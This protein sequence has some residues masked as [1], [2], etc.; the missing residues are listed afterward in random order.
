MCRLSRTQWFCAAF[1]LVALRLVIGWHFFQEGTAKLRAGNFSAEGFFRSANGPAADFYRRLIDDGDGRLRLGL[2]QVTKDPGHVEWDLDPLVT[3]ET[4]KG[5]LY[6]AA[7]HYGFG[8]EALVEQLERR[9]E[10]NRKRLAAEPPLEP[11]QAD[12]L[13]TQIASDAAEIGRIREQ[14][15]AGL[16]IVAAYSERLRSF[17]AENRTEIL[18]YFRGADRLRGFDKDGT[19]RT[20][21]LY[22]VAS[23]YDQTQQISRERTSAAR[24][25][26]EQVNAMWDGVETEI[27]GLAVETQ[28]SRGSVRLERPWAPRFSALQIINRVVPWFDTLVGVLL[29]LGLFTRWA[30][31]AGALFLAGVISTQPPFVMGSTPTI[32]QLVELVGLL[33]LLATGAGRLA[34]FDALW[35]RRAPRTA[36]RSEANA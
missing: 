5:F 29:V 25:W 19:T 10:A 33:V 11:A 31:L 3:E 34:G 28:V 23:L 14:K 24:P 7:R 4:W 15:E 2:V 9:R 30:A 22:G 32:Y 35:V 17:L 26:L 18:A 21:V 8:D 36:I 27:N 16:A 20:D 13:K 6:R 1:S 12:R